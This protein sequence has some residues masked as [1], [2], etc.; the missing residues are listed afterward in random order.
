MYEETYRRIRAELSEGLDRILMI[1]H[2]ED[3]KNYLRDNNWAR[4]T[5]IILDAFLH[6][7]INPALLVDRKVSWFD[8][9]FGLDPLEHH[10]AEYRAIFTH[11]KDVIET[12]PIAPPRRQV[13]NLDRLSGS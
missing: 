4:L 12:L 6:N 3:F 2:G 7:G 5:Q 10:L 9:F 11:L 1:H 13:I 8:S